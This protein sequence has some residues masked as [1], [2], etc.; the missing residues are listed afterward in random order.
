MASLWTYLDAAWKNVVT[1]VGTSGKLAKWTGTYTQGDATNTDA[2]VADSVTKKHTQNTD[3]DLDATFKATLE[4]VANKGAANGYASLDADSLVV[5]AIKKI[6]VA[7]SAPGTPS[8]GDIYID[9]A[10]D[11]MFIA[12]G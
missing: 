8:E 3:T 6:R 11:A 4:K 5:E 12:V 2:D 9:S 7:N 10:E 1:G